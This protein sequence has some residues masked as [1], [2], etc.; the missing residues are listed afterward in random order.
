MVACS[1]TSHE[2]EVAA[3]QAGPGIKVNGA[4]VSI[5]EATVPAGLDCA[6]GALVRRGASGW[7]C[8]QTAPDASSLGGRPA[9]AYLT[10]D[11]TA[12][13]ASHLGGWPASAYVTSGWGVAND[14]ARLGGI[15]ASSYLTATAGTANDAAR[16]GGRLPSEFVQT[17]LQ[18]DIEAGTHRQVFSFTDASGATSRISADGLYCGA[19]QP[20]GATFSAFDP[21]TRRS[22]GGYRAAKLLCEQADGC[23][24]ATAHMCSGS[25]MVRSAQIGAFGAADQGGWIATGASQPSSTVAAVGDCNGWTNSTS[26]AKATAWHA[27]GGIAA[28]LQ[29]SCD[30]TLAI[31]CC[32]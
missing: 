10:A 17:T 14:S 29:T 23:G 25:E 24:A 3:I 16:F 9:S 26:S 6:A 28:A 5:D 32:R 13:N 31:L 21:T 8:V 18:A 12:G 4:T 7:E 27:T 19:T 1:A 22:V 20:V 11:G 2:A 15:P 30:A